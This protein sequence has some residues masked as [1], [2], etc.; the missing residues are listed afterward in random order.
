MPRDPSSTHIR[1]LFQRG[2]AA[3]LDPASA[4]T[5]P[6]ADAVTTER[7]PW[8]RG[9]CVRC[10][11]SFRR[12]DRVRA[13]GAI[14]AVHAAGTGFCAGDA[15]EPPIEETAAEA[16]Y[17]GLAAACTPP[18]R[19]AVTRL[20][21]GHWL[22]APPLAGL[23]RRTCVVCGHTL[24]PHDDVIV[25]PC[26]PEMPLCEAA[27]HQ[28]NVHGLSCLTGWNEREARRCCPVTAVERP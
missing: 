12:G 21:P 3:G 28:D 11:H 2:L 14:Q 8:L 5:V 25:C 7:S 10:G 20:L 27:V 19:L 1:T 15:A 17:R 4:I 6:G 13:D 26:R 22:L 9:R 23:G 16:F 24:R 18:S